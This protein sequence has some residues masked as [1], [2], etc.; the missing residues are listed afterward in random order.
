MAENINLEQDQQLDQQAPIPTLNELAD[1]SASGVPLGT[2]SGGPGPASTTPG[3]AKPNQTPPSYV[4]SLGAL[5]DY[6]YSQARTQSQFA[7][8]AWLNPTITPKAYVQKFVDMPG[9][10]VKGFDNE[11]Y[12]AQQEGAFKT[13]GKGIGRLVLGTGIKVGQSVGYTMGLLDPSNWDSDIITKAADNGFSQVMDGLDKKMQDEWLPTFQEASDRNK[14]FWWR[15][16]NDGDFW[17]TDVMD[18]LAFMASAWIPG[19]AL[20]KLGVG[21]KAAKALSGLKIGVSAAEATVQGAASASNY[22]TKAN[23]IFR[24]GIDKFNAWALATSGEAMFEANETKHKIYDS[25]TTD[26]LTGRLV[27]NPLTLLPYT[28]E[29]KKRIAGGAAKNTFVLNAGLLGATNALELSW[30]GKI[31]GGEAQGALKGVKGATT[32]AEELTI[33]APTKMLN[34]FLS[35]KPAAF[36]KGGLKGVG[37][38]GFLEENAQ[39]AIQRVNEHYG[40][41]GKIADAFNINE[42]VSQYAK[43]T[44]DAVA[45]RDIEASTSIG[46][47]GILG[48]AGGGISSVKDYNANKAYTQA[49]ISSFNNA[50]E[51]FLKFGNIYKT[52]DVVTKDASGNPITTQKIAIGKDGQPI[53]DTEKVAGIL[54]S[55]RSVN[56]AIDEAANTSDGFKKTILKDTA[57]SQFVTAHISAGIEDTLLEKLDGVKKATP[58]AIAKLGFELDKDLDK[59]ITR[60]KNL[61][62]TIIN[63]NKLINSDIMFDD[64]AEDKM[65]KAYMISIAAEQAV[66]KSISNEMIGEAE[67]IKGQFLDSMN[68]SLSDGLVDQLNSYQARINSQEDFIKS[69]EKNKYSQETIDE[70]KQVLSELKE[71][72]ETIIKDNELS[73]EKVKKEKDE[74]GYYQYEKD[75]RNELALQK[76]YLKKIKVRGEIQ[77]HIRGI[78]IKWAKFADTIDGKKN[79]MDF[80]KKDTMDRI[81]QEQSGEQTT[82]ETTAGAPPEEGKEEKKSSGKLKLSDLRNRQKG[83]QQAGETSEDEEDEEDTPEEEITIT[84]ENSETGEEESFDFVIGGTYKAEYDNGESDTLVVTGFDEDSNIV[85]YTLNDED[86]TTADAD[87]FAEYASTSGFVVVKKEKQKS[88]PKEKEVKRKATRKFTAKSDN[89]QEIE[90]DTDIVSDPETSTYTTDKKNPKF[91]EVGFYKTFG[92]HYIDNNDTKLNTIAGSERFYEFTSNFDLSK[93][94]VL[95][96]VTKNNDNFKIRQEKFNPEDIKVIVMKEVKK[97]KKTSY[98]YVDVENNIIPKEDASKENIIYSSLADYSN[99]SVAL[100]KKNYTVDKDTT[101]K[102]IQDQIDAHIKYQKGLLN[103]TKNNKEV[104][105]TITETSPGIQNYQFTKSI[106]KNNQPELAMGPVEGRIVADGTDYRALQSATNPEAYYSLKVNTIEGGILPNLLPGRL[107]MEEYTFND[108]KKVRTKRGLRVFNRLL[109]EDEKDTITKALARFSELFGRDPKSEKAL[110]LEENQE[111]ALIFDYLRGMLNWSAPIEGRSPG[112]YV[113]IQNGLHIGDTVYKFDKETI[114]ENADMMLNGIYHHVNNR[115]LWGDKNFPFQTIKMV[116][117]KAVAGTAYDTY[118]KYLLAKRKDGELPPVYTALPLV[119]SG[120]PQRKSSYIKW[121]DPAD[122]EAKPMRT[123]EERTYS[124]DT[125]PRRAYSK[126]DRVINDFINYRISN[127]TLMGKKIYYVKEKGKFWIVFEDPKTKKIQ[128]SDAYKSVA[129]MVKDKW[130]TRQRMYKFSG[131]DPDAVAEEKAT[132]AKGKKETKEKETTKGKKLKLSDLLAKKRGLTKGKKTK[133]QTNVVKVSDEVDNEIQEGIVTALVRSTSYHN[134]FY[135][136]DGVYSTEQGSGVELVHRGLVKLKGNTIWGSDFRFTK[137]EFADMMGYLSWDDFVADASMSN[138]TLAEGKPVEFYDVSPGEL[139]EEEDEEEPI[140]FEAQGSLGLIKLNVIEQQVLDGE[141][142]TTVR[143][144]R[145]HNEFYKGDGIYTSENGNNFNIEYKGLIKKVGN[146]IKSTTKGYSVNYTLDD[147]AEAEGYSDWSTFTKEAQYSGVN[148]IKGEEVHLYDISAA[149]EVE[150]AKG[151][152]PKSVRELLVSRIK[153]GKTNLKASKVTNKKTQKKQKQEEEEEE[154]DESNLTAKELQ[155]LRARAL[156]K[157]KANQKDN[158]KTSSSSS[159]KGQKYTTIDDAVENA[160]RVGNKLKGDVWMVNPKTN[161][162]KLDFSAE[163]EIFNNNIE[164]AKKLLT[165]KLNEQVPFRLSL[166][167]DV[168][169][170]EN[171][172][173]LDKFLQEKLPQFSVQKMARLINGKAWGAFYNNILYIYDKA[174]IGTGFH[175]AFEGVWAAYLT[176]DEQQELADEFRSREGKFT[177]PFSRE[178][179]SYKDASMYDVREMLSEEFR[180][181]MLN[182]ETFSIKNVGKKTIGFFQKLWNTIKSFFGMKVEEREELDSKINSVFKSI[183]AG[184]F[185]EIKPI[186]ELNSISPSFRDVE[187]LTQTEMASIM[188]GLK[189]Y[190][191][192]DIYSRGSNVAA[193]LNSLTKEESNEMLAKTFAKS[194]GAVLSRLDRSPNT[195]TKVEASRLKI[196]D[197]FKKNLKK[198]GLIFEEEIEE[199]KVSDPLGIRDSITIDPRTMTNGNVRMLLDSI[200]IRDAEGRMKANK[201]SQPRLYSGDKIHIALKNEL[202]NITSTINENLERND[203]LPQMFEALD[204]KFFDEETGDYKEGYSWIMDLKTRINYSDATGMPIDGT[205]LSKDEMQLKI[206]F[207]KSFTN[208]KTNPEKLIVGANGYIYNFNPILETNIARVKAEWANNLKLQL[209]NNQNKIITVDQ[210]GALLIDRDSTDYRTLLRLLNNPS[211]IDLE[212]SL[213]V[214]DI[215]GIEFSGSDEEIESNEADIIISAKSILTALKKGEINSASDIYSGQTV[216]GPMN[217]L[218]EI[219]TEFSSE[220]NVLSYVNADGEQQYSIMNPSLFSQMINT[221]N[222]VKSLKEL[223]ITCPWLGY[224]NENDEVVLNPYQENSELLRPGG[225]LFKE[226]GDRRKGKNELLKYHVISGIGLTDS[227][228]SV[229]AK[230]SFP[231]RVANEIHYLLDNTVFSN[232]NSDKSMEY[233][234][235]I[236]GGLY[237]NKNDVTSYLTDNKDNTKIIDKYVGHLTDEMAS[238]VLQ[239]NEPAYIQFYTD[240]EIGV[241]NLGHFR[242][243]LSTEM[244]DKFKKE[245]LGKDAKYAGVDAHSKF[246][247]K[248][249]KELKEEISSYISNQ[250]QETLEFLYNELDMFEDVSKDQTGT[251]FISD[252]ISNEQLNKALNIDSKNQKKNEDG[253]AIYSESDIVALAGIITINKELLATEQ[254]KLI[255]G[256]PAMYKDYAKRANGATSTKEPIVEDA[257]T[258]QWMDKNMPRTDGKERALDVHQTFKV[259]SFKDQNV[260]SAFYQRSLEAIYKS[261]LESGTDPKMA[262]RKVGATFDAKNNLTGFIKEK[263]KYTGAAKAYLEMTEADAMAWGMPDF[264]RDLLF[265]SAKITPQQEAQWDYE[266]AYEMVARYSKPKSDLSYKYYHPSELKGAK[267]ILKKGDPGYVFNVLKPQYFGYATT[268][269]VTHPVFLKHAVQP[270]FYRHVEGTQYESIYI[271]SKNN[272][273]DVVGFESGQKV[274]AATDTNGKL[275]S[276]YN[277]NG[278]PNIRVIKK[279]GQSYYDFPETLVKQDLYTRFYGIQVEVSSKP[280]RSVVRGTQVTK[281]IMANFFKNGQPITP[282]LGRKIKE[283]NDTLVEMIRLGKQ[284][285]IRELGLERDSKGNYKTKDLQKLIDIL[286]SEAIDRDMPANVIEAIQGIKNENGEETLKYSFDTLINRQKIDNILNS[287]VDSRVISEKMSGKSSVQVSST[288]Y[289]S[290]NN[291]RDFMYLLD[292][293][294]T[295]LTKAAIPNLTKEQKESIKMTSTD[296]KFYYDNAGNVTTMECYVSWPYKDVTPEQVGLVLKDGVYKIPPNGTSTFDKELLRIIGF[297]I[298]TQSPNSIENI[299][300]KGFTPATNGDMIVVPSE[301][302]AKSGSDFDIDKL[303]LYFNHA[304]IEPFTKDYK[305]EVFKKHMINYFMN[306]QGY[307]RKQAEALYKSF[308]PEELDQINQSAYNERRREELDV[309]T[310]LED[311]NFR[312]ITVLEKVK[313]GIESFN[314]QYKGK[315]R[316]K[317]VKPGTAN[318]DQ[319]QNKFISIM[320][321]LISNSKNYGQLV[322]PNR[323]DTLKELATNI[324]EAKVKAGTKKEENEKSPTFLRTFIGSSKTRERYLTAKRMVGIAALNSTFHV[325]AQVAGLKLNDNFKTKP[326]S[327]LMPKYGGKYEK[328]KDIDIR[329]SHY[330]KNEN[331]TYDIGHIVDMDKQSISDLISEALTGFVDGAKDPFVFDLNFSLNSAG[332]WFYLQHMGVP[333]EEIAYFFNQPIMDEYFLQFAKNKAAFKK[334]NGKSLYNADLF[335]EVVAPYYNKVF[336]TDMLKELK[337]AKEDRSNPMAY[338]EKGSEIIEKIREAGYKYKKFDIATL[339]TQISKGAKADAKLQMYILVHY[340]EY[341]TQARYLGNYMGAITYDTRKTRT[342]QEGKYQMSKWNRSIGEK[343]IANPDAILKNTF[344][345]EM[346]I[347]KQDIVDNMFK[348]FFVSLDPEIQSLF[349]PLYEKLDNPD[350]FGTQE[351]MTNYV[352]KYQNFIL[353]YILHTTP[354]KN[355]K[356][357]KETLNSLYS[358]LFTG[359]KTLPIALYNLKKSKDTSISNNLVVKELLP[360]ISDDMI[361]TDNLKLFRSKMETMEIN[362]VVEALTDLKDYAQNTANKDL[363]KFIDDLAKFSIIQSGFDSGY[364]DFRKVLSIDVYSEF[365]KTILDNFKNSSNLNKINPDMVWRNFHQNNWY[366]KELVPLVPSYITSFELRSGMFDLGIDTSAAVHDYLI[367]YQLKPNMKYKLVKL[368][369]EKRLGEAFTPMLF[370]KLGDNANGNKVIYQRIG[371]KGNKNKMLE[372]YND[373]TPS[374]FTN[375]NTVEGDVKLGNK[376]LEAL[377]DEIDEEDDTLDFEIDIPVRKIISGGQTGVDRM[378]LEVGRDLGY[379]TGGTAPKGFKTE[380]ED[381]P[382]LADFGLVENNSTNYSVRTKQNVNDS[383]G[384]VLFGNMQSPGSL[385]TIKFLKAS[386]RPYIENPNVTELKN[387]LVENEIETLNVAGNRGSKLLKKD[388]DKFRKILTDALSMPVEKTTTKKLL[389]KSS[390]KRQQ[391][392][393]IK[394]LINSIEFNVEDMTPE[395]EDIFEILDEKDYEK[396]QGSLDQEQIIKD[397]ESTMSKI[398]SEEE[399]FTILTKYLLPRYID[400][401]LAEL[402]ASKPK[403]KTQKNSPKGK[404]AIKRSPKKC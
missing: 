327:Y 36:I 88:S 342:I 216:G 154:S 304:I 267:E 27:I 334:A 113:W 161:E 331:E 312:D 109:T 236:P 48:V 168:E 240:D 150:V 101:D 373:S 205:T 335:Y 4:P 369:K 282:E 230:L 96:V 53:I 398:Q 330:P 7:D 265:S 80:V 256:H 396:W 75:Q 100:V 107:V 94:Y 383:D 29:E 138:L 182:G 223:I 353:S 23:S 322:Q 309:E 221:L 387:W 285:L 5:A 32:L 378:G 186:R 152:K 391:L 260:V 50:Q 103:R 99:L 226:N 266:N 299:I 364:L 110:D 314:K 91:E 366:S 39:L 377:F 68:T 333:V 399:G 276:V 44:L 296:L 284:S 259:V 246:I 317:Y 181:Y 104:Y 199:E 325:M 157:R 119:E 34:K 187:D 117:G 37:A 183:K 106:G 77:N 220:D 283:Y 213:G 31:F 189:Y 316:I 194:F 394:D 368:A 277:E 224:F 200:P 289:E 116:K 70:A 130:K 235:G 176:D 300:I 202:S 49:A 253:N 286:V 184:E 298:P 86:E 326:I 24:T 308:T 263:G 1:M 372:I 62:T 336:K 148:L 115:M 180:S 370:E 63:Q 56:G 89:P 192:T 349:K 357:K 30:L 81:V 47:G 214:L 280:K 170:T 17:M 234:M 361:G 38:E 273:V 71:D 74:N 145:Y 124:R 171:F 40:V 147:F 84:Y 323:T 212:I 365:V 400:S 18:G 14:G 204:K 228:G 83:E 90:S 288:L 20:S 135:T 55:Y 76:Q 125:K 163:V 287:I 82:E 390:D 208:I 191:F 257:D 141:A 169:K 250:I 58:E 190:F 201:L 225:I 360:L 8:A 137:K 271:A 165:D 340:L 356:G 114:L 281:L 381:D 93:G 362:N 160:V 380:K 346:K 105:L 121:K 218:L 292:G 33:D 233:G 164:N 85:S 258:I 310:S 264:I 156:S 385:E 251:H 129:E 382:T 66:Y 60:Y 348:N 134:K 46:I 133:V 57:F 95:R 167:E 61:A 122:N 295:P 376:F 136:E 97:N 404:P 143:S 363:I 248:N 174:E 269:G 35:G 196:Y 54:S 45:G 151:K 149:D 272:Q 321:D 166:S 207:I 275:T 247:K 43:Q 162:Y 354:Y 172:K 127:M 367:K 177:N 355:S 185:A 279:A 209:Q 12:Y 375:N 238:A 245:V 153:K 139:V 72:Q 244:L 339:K 315:M 252:A 92:K 393:N 206:A 155:E 268:L 22:L 262:S 112:R 188:E 401:K 52:Q 217:K 42:L 328:S 242:N 254:H 64:S 2:N 51:N 261:M 98:E 78:G 294:Y 311:L 28:E 249:L 178:T 173:A 291:P 6:S 403:N 395:M 102:Q 108:N 132:K 293:V 231:E 15:A 347:Q 179:K 144:D 306:D 337:Q 131:Y 374:I 384:T 140:D 358:N 324:K 232:I 73:M 329:L 343:F 243:I 65:R 21:V 237:V 9:G 303:N 222:S 3:V 211:A 302:V 146:K 195:R 341:A 111:L 352:N 379:E 359:L 219:E 69:L 392:I 210:S 126:V 290:S 229:T 203:V 278:K 402:D 193:I 11:D 301:I 128:M 159:S 239:M 67:T 350:F 16:F 158:K 305:S 344:L 320:Q 123:K 25:L 198:Y 13:F 241:N 87:E 351:D 59:Q 197:L 10:Y 227:D 389:K 386:K 255:Y 397:L 297:R 215:F 118:E 41:K 79:F 274:G 175:E 313:Q 19:L 26:P 332:T 142:S 371:L 319:L 388:L 345:G 307:T 318:K 338:S 120:L 270:K